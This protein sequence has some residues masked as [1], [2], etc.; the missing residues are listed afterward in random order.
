MQIEQF[1]NTTFDTIEKLKSWEKYACTHEEPYNILCNGSNCWEYE[2]MSSR[3]TEMHMKNIKIKKLLYIPCPSDASD[4][5]GY[6]QGIM[7]DHP[8]W[9]A[10]LHEMKKY[11]KEWERFIKYYE[12]CEK[13][14][15][16][17]K[18][19]SV[20]DVMK[21]F[22]KKICKLYFYEF[23]QNTPTVELKE[24]LIMGSIVSHNNLDEFDIAHVCILN[25]LPQYQ[26]INSD[27]YLERLTATSYNKNK[28]KNGWFTISLT[29]PNKLNDVSSDDEI[30][31]IINI[32]KKI[33]NVSKNI[34]IPYDAKMLELYKR[35][36]NREYVS[37]SEIPKW[38]DYLEKSI[39]QK[40]EDKLK[41]INDKILEYNNILY[42]SDTQ[43]LNYEECVN[44]NIKLGCLKNEIKWFINDNKNTDNNVKNE[45]NKINNQLQIQMTKLGN[46]YLNHYLDEIQMHNQLNEYVKNNSDIFSNLTYHYCPHYI[47]YD[48]KDDGYDPELFSMH[49]VE[50]DY[51][52]NND[53]NNFNDD[54]FGIL[55]CIISI[56]KNH[57]LH[58]DNSNGSVDNWIG[59][60]WTISDKINKCVVYEEGLQNAC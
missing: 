25:N 32:E 10:R 54:N 41:S 51:C 50:L 3:L 31:K 8:E 23:P 4:F 39:T 42:N 35:Y 40:N 19:I 16:E 7:K 21:T 55:T 6:S 43:N 18:Y 30:N 28:T 36:K 20:C 27:G 14:V 48:E 59:M 53:D 52:N 17:G 38:H 57:V 9:K 22:N 33:V 60:N 13:L 1:N 45:F 15:Q 24:Y 29:H 2:G 12:D 11:G 26:S 47:L 5:V 34:N 58:P 37:E 44:Y 46:A 56:S 49:S